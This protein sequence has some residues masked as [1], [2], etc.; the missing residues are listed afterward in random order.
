MIEYEDKLAGALLG[1]A[2][3][4]ALGLPYE[5]L[6]R[7]RVAK[8]IGSRPL[9]HRFCFGRGMVSDDT[10]HTCMIAQA[11]LA[12]P[13][14]L[15]GFIH[16]LSWSLRRWLLCM[17]AGIGKATLRSI[18][19][20]WLGFPPGRSGVWSAGNGPAMRAAILG[21][22]L[23]HDSGRLRA[24]VH[25]STRITHTDP[26]AERGAFLVALAAAHGVR[27]DNQALIGPLTLEPIREELGQ[28]DDELNRA[29]DQV[30]AHLQRDA[31]PESFADELGLQKG[32]TGYIYHSVPM[33]L[34]CW[35]RNPG[36]FRQAV[37]DVI[38]LGGDTDTTGAIVGGL[39]GATVGAQGIP[40]PWLDG[41][42][43]WPQTVGWMRCLASHLAERLM[44]QGSAAN[45]NS[46]NY[47]WPGRLPRNL[48][49]VALVLGHAF[50]RLL[51]PY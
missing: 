19:K 47:F 17:P 42:A 41:L 12:A 48:F 10:E 8:L 49:F 40:L 18:V 46:P 32:V 15:D 22:S 44:Q 3:G 14:D 30:D 43:E 11:L 50:R 26:R 2:M 31:S 13:D 39:A 33:A 36:N 34:Y 45:T 27:A 29:L 35:L 9:E 25:A 24:Y 28:V 38:R 23:G 5:N 51:P 37:E 7:R 6:S 21:A 20:L 1:T 16:S 4:D